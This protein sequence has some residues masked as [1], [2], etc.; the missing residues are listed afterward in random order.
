[1]SPVTEGSVE[2]L[3]LTLTLQICILEYK[4]NQKRQTKGPNDGL[5]KVQL[6]S[7]DH[8]FYCYWKNVTINPDIF[9]LILP[10]PRFNKLALIVK[11]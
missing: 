9:F 3:I 4:E 8:Q 7:N 2:Q 1:M 11:V 10:N 5:M 6:S